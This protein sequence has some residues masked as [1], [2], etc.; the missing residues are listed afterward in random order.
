M[1]D[2]RRFFT[3]QKCGVLNEKN[4]GQTDLLMPEDL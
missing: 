1:K 4:R 3:P 2:V